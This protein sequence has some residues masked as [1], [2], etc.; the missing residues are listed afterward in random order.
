MFHTLEKGAG[1]HKCCNAIIRHAHLFIVYPSP[2][3]ALTLDMRKEFSLDEAKQHGHTLTHTFSYSFPPGCIWKL[4]GEIRE[5]VK[6]SNPNSA[7]IPN[8]C[9]LH[10]LKF[11]CSN[12]CPSLLR[13]W[14]TDCKSMPLSHIYNKDTNN[15]VSKKIKNTCCL[16]VR[17][18]VL[19]IRRHKRI[20]NTSVSKGFK[21]TDYLV[22]GHETL[23]LLDHRNYLFISLWQTESLHG[24][25]R[26]K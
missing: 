18:C 24:V 26:G 17:L 6:L 10:R 19:G 3:T 12:A 23:C 1:K 25:C 16:S 8:A 5:Q 14:S 2:V 15:R 22:L 7:T 4:G 20:L 9:C 21:A 13:T 11:C